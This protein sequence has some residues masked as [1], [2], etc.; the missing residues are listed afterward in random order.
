VT[1]S[2]CGN[3]R[4]GELD[5]DAGGGVWLVERRCR[6]TAWRRTGST[7]EAMDR[8]RFG[9]ALGY[10]ARHAAKAVMGAVDAATAPDP[11][12]APALRDQSVQPATE[13][14]VQAYRQV[15]EVKAQAGRAAKTSFWAPLK[16]FSSVISLQVAGTFFAVLA[17]FLGE[18]VWQQ[19]A[20]FRGGATAAAEWKLAISMAVFVVFTYFA[21]SSFIRAG[22]HERR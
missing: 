19:R 3:A 15:S 22:R 14:V 2:H 21:L 12:A 20:V 17:A 5:A 7:L 1:S 16:R 13:R 4:C 10:G 6:G 8:V 18:G 11:R 9:R